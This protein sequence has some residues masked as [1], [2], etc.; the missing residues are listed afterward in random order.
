MRQGLGSTVAYDAVANDQIDLYV[1]YSGTVWA[2]NMKREDARPRDAL[3]DEMS[4]WLLST[5]NI[6]AST[7]SRL[8]KR[9]RVCS[10][11]RDGAALRP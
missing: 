5:Q 2:T 1:D 7:P 9:L 4:Q 8:R 11:P 6:V 3:Y 10:Q